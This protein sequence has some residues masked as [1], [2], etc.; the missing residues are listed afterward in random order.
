MHDQVRMNRAAALALL[1]LLA[2]AC[3]SSA[4]TASHSSPS[5]SW[6][7]SAESTTPTPTS[8]TASSTP[9]PTG[10]PAASPTSSSD[11]PFS[12]LPSKQPVGFVST[13]TCS[14]SIGASDPVAIVQLHSAAGTGELVLR[15]YA[16]PK[17]P[18]TACRFHAQVAQLIDARHVVI[19][20]NFPV[21]AVVDLPEVRYHWFQLPRPPGFGAGLV[22]VSPGLNEIAWVSNDDKTGGNRK[23]HLATTSGD[24]V[25]ANLRPALGRCGSAEDSKNGAYVHSGSHLYVLDQPILPSNILVVLQGNKQVL[26]LVP[27]TAGWSPG[28]QPA[29][30]VWSPTSQTLFYRQKGDVWQWTPAGGA[31]R[32]LP[33]VNW[34]YPT[35]TPDG[36]H[37][38]YAVV[39]SDGLHNVYLID[40]A[41]GGGPKLI[42]KGARN[43]PVFLNSSQL[44]YKSEAKGI[45]GPGTNQPLVY[46]ITNASESTSVIDQV[47]AV[48]PATSSNF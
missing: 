8:S 44:W 30:A 16:D 2:T 4:G 3:G 23:V 26:S 11:T 32:Y 17:S 28:A 24:Q 7:P 47:T 42:G 13:I 15:D 40:L 1:L 5:T 18:R 9:T 46:D 25:V 39:R 10:S 20:V 41:N 34:Y 36:G 33:G 43:L 22:A 37:L 6:S 14:G 45:C 19:G 27:P 21:Y 12:V 31:Q 29:M 35:I 48:W 38:A